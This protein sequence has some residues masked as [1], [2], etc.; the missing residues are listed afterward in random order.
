MIPCPPYGGDSNS[1]K[2]FYQKDEHSEAIHIFFQDKKGLKH[3]QQLFRNRM[4][5]LRNNSL[6]IEY[7]TEDDQ[8]LY[9][10]R[11][12]FQD[13]CRDEPPT[14]LSVKKGNNYCYCLNS[15]HLPKPILYSNKQY[16]FF[17]QKF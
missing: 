14:F 12:C 1:F 3:H 5:V 2:W 10:C 17:F 15:I 16:L 8:G 9:W 7:F 6:V 13:N 11:N 4:R